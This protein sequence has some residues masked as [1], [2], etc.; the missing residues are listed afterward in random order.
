P[1]DAERV[2][3]HGPAR[4]QAAAKKVSGVGGLNCLQRHCF[5][6][7]S[8]LVL[9]VMMG[10]LLGLRSTLI[11][12]NASS[13]SRACHLALRPTPSMASMPFASL[14]GRPPPCFQSSCS[15]C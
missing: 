13:M 14:I 4:F 3:E 11:R 12:S 2:E 15:R 5:H 6:G 1:L 9:R 8:R 10:D 7:L